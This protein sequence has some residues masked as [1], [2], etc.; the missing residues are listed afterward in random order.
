MKVGLYWEDGIFQAA[1]TAENEH[2]QKVVDL[3]K[4]RDLVEVKSGG[5]YHC[6]GGWIRQSNPDDKDSVML[7]MKERHDE[8][9]N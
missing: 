4:Q 8:P 3:L 5:F 7:I 1:L 2:E 9:G 6:Q